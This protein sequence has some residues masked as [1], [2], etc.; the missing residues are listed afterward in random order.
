MPCWVTKDKEP[1]SNLGVGWARPS[2]VIFL[3]VKKRDAAR[4]AQAR[5]VGGL[6]PGAEGGVAGGRLLVRGT[7]RD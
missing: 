1:R 6:R 4:S 2:R 7:A 3:R 5:K